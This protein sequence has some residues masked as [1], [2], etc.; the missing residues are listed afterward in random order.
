MVIWSFEWKFFSQ[1]STDVW[2]NKDLDTVF[3]VCAGVENLLLVSD[4]AKP[5]L[6]QMLAATDMRPKSLFFAVNLMHPQLDLTKILHIPSSAVN[7]MHED[8]RHWP[9]IFRLPALPHLGLGHTARPSLV[10]AI[11]AAASHLEILILLVAAEEARTAAR[12][13]SEALVLHDSRVVLVGPI[14][15]EGFTL[16]TGTHSLNKVWTRAEEFVAR[17]RSGEIPEASAESGSGRGLP[18]LEAGSLLAD[19]RLEDPEATSVE[20]TLESDVCV[21]GAEESGVAEG[22]GESDVCV[23]GAEVCVEDTGGSDVWLLDFDESTHVELPSSG[24]LQ[25]ATLQ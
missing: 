16:H 5:L 25:W 12:S 1:P 6:L 7:F 10:Q 2:S 4:L 17:K 11:F 14:H 3:H 15:V 21:K 8:W 23:A 20:E 13:F 9:T 22:A 24:D 19:L 18:A